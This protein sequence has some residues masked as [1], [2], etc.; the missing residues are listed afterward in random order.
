MKCTACGKDLVKKDTL[1][2][3]DR[4]P[5]CNNTLTCNDDHPNS[6][7]NILARQGAEQMFTEDELEHNIFEDLNVTDE[8][9][10]RIMKIAT[11]P[12]SIRLSKVDISYYLIQ[13][14]DHHN[15]A[16]L[17][18]AIRYC[19]H[20]AKTVEPL[21]GT[22][23]DVTDLTNEIVKEVKEEAAEA[24]AG[25]KAVVEEKSKKVSGKDLIK[26]QI[27]EAKVE[28]ETLTF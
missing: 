19:V 6:V 4:M 28:D 21:D 1:Y 14:Q 15:L 26:K 17:S 7:K 16:S 2:T 9:K 27:E 3:K 13:L 12:Q 23:P 25:I 11:K 18:E 8:M 5:Y 22:T 20:L 10:E 24:V